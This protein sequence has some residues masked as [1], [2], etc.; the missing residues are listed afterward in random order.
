[1]LNVKFMYVYVL[2]SNVLYPLIFYFHVLFYKEVC[3]G[4][5]CNADSTYI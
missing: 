5:S 3:H 1:M 4:R 2:G